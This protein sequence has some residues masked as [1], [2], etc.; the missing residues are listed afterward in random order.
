[1][2]PLHLIL[3]IKLRKRYIILKEKTTTSF[4]GLKFI[5]LSLWILSNPEY[6]IEKKKLLI[7]LVLSFKQEL[8]KLANF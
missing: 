4:G 8:S 6:M 1:M 3:R 2:G 7:K 5:D